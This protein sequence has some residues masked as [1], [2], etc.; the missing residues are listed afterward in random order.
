MTVTAEEI[1]SRVAGIAPI[2]AANVQACIEARRVVPASRDAMVGAGLFRI[3]QPAR[4]GGYELPLRILG[5]AVTAVSEACPASGWV[6]M[7]MAAHH[8]CLGTFPERAQDD[9]FG[10]GRDSLV[11]GTL[12]WQGTAA[13]VAGGYRVNG[14]WQFC[15]GVDNS[16]WVMLGCADA[17]KGGPLV[18]V[19][20]PTG[21][22]A[23]DDTWYVLGL[24]GT[25]SKDVVATDLFVPEGHAVDSRAMLKGDSPHTLNHATNLYRVSADSMLSLSV[26]TA[27]LGSAKF[28][29][30]KFIERTK[31]RRVI[32]TGARKAE[33]VPTQLR[34]AEAAAEIRCADLLIHESL[35]LLGRVA[36]AG[37]GA[38][39]IGYRAQV[40]WHAAYAIELCRRAVSR[41]FAGSGAH[42]V[43]NSSPL[44]L[45][46]RNVNVGAQ[47]ASLDF[48]TSAELY[49]RMR[50][51]LLAR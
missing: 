16:N 17:E 11:A 24:E 47:H 48:E 25:G 21:E 29:Q 45:A 50:L 23:I 41:L 30:E 9:V 18:H 49:G 19:V 14:R 8:F 2:L 20:V 38:T 7:V 43:Y 39:D 46:F 13:K 12:S 28:A 15:S 1:Q 40:K 4:V 10:G 5:D 22:I 36:E 44:Q 27:T 31:E 33:Y 35:D 42:A 26:A 3:P 37:E 34:L 6:L 51:G 32:V